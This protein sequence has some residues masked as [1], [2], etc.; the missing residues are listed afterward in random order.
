MKIN[1]LFKL[2]FI[3]L[4]LFNCTKSI[5]QNL[6]NHRYIVFDITG[7]M[8]GLGTGSD[9]IW[10]KAVNLLEKQLRTFKSGEK[11]SLFLYGT[12]VY[13][14]GSYVIDNSG[15]SIEKILSIV[16]EIRNSNSFEDCTC[17]Y[18]AL[19]TV[20]NQFDTENYINTTYLFTDGNQTLNCHANCRKVTP[21]KVIS[22]F[23]NVTKDKGSDYL[24]IYK[25]KPQIILAD[26]F[27]NNPKIKIIENALT[28]LVVTI[29]PVNST[30]ML[31]KD[32]LTSKQK[33]NLTGTG[34]T[35]FLNSNSLNIK[36]SE[37]TLNN[38]NN[39]AQDALFLPN[40]IN[41][42]T[43]IQEIKLVPFNNLSL[44]ENV[45]YEGNVEYVFD[46]NSSITQV[47]SGDFNI[48]IEIL[49]SK[50]KVIFN[51]TQPTVTIEFIDK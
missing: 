12:D 44:F 15:D 22:N 26:S 1:K 46:N 9:D 21:D 11:I 18:F 16:K 30:I 17:T 38:E 2:L 3:L 47:R 14:K 34:V 20:F 36:L 7:S 31:N 37:F 49:P 40:T 35:E 42:N 39:T 8:V 33:F 43:E 32:I 25:L 5:S 50:T 29:T 28:E 23:D 51:N 6:K 10:D 24:F 48:N 4:V 45:I 41:V 19:N 13:N 27:I